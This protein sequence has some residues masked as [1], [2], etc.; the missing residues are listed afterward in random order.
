MQPICCCR[1]H[2]GAEAEKRGH[3]LGRQESGAGASLLG[4][5]R[6]TCVARTQQAWGVFGGGAAWA[7]GSVPRDTASGHMVGTMELK[8]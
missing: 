6:L 2:S 8:T 3:Q 5:P 7:D 1:A 4:L